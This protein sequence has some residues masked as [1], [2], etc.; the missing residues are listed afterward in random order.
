MKRKLFAALAVSGLFLAS[1]SDDDKEIV[2][3]EPSKGTELT[4]LNGSIAKDAVLKG[5]AISLKGATIVR[6]GATLTIPAGTTITATEKTAYLLIERGAKIIAKGTSASPIKFTSAVNKSGEW[7]G[8]II[9]GKAPISRAKESDESVAGTEINTQILYGGNVSNDNSGELDYVIIENSGSN[10][11]E[12]KEHNGLTL[13]A[14]GSGTKISNIYIKAGADDGIEFFGG[15]VNVTNLLV[16]NSEDDMFD[17]TEGYTGTL[18]NAYGIWET[19]F[20]SPN[21]PD[22]RGIEAD[23]NKD[24]KTPADFGQSNFTMKDITIVNNSTT[25]TGVMKPIVKIRRGA[26]ANISNLK[27]LFGATSKYTDIIDFTDG[28]GKGNASSKIT[29]T[30]EPENIFDATKIKAEGATITKNATSTGANTSV[31]AWTKYSF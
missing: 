8:L 16:V 6:A 14:V 5:N 17:V 18:T 24:G 26:T 12:E 13:N 28:A 31:F 9:N 11:S 7:G 27:I 2:T 21:E 10:I 30:F 25:A 19:G 20:V 15:T 1:C 29:Y 3:P 23:G 22:P 4:E